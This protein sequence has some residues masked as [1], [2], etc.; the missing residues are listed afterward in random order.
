MF[1]ATEPNINCDLFPK[2]DWT[3]AA[4]GECLEELPVNMPELR[5]STIVTRAF[6]DSDHADDTATRRSRTGFVIFLNNASIYWFSNR[7]TSVETSSFGSEFVVMK[8]CCEY[9]LGLRYKLRMMGINVN[10]PT[11]VFGD[12]QS[13]LANVSGPHLKL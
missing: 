12:N 11:F 9:I 13:V 10:E 2:D 1:D 3:A 6:V 8:L 4:Y 7:Q 5:E